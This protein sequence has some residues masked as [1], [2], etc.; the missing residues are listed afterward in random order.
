MKLQITDKMI[1][2]IEDPVQREYF[3]DIK[4]RID[5]G[6]KINPN[7]LLNGVSELMGK[8]N[9]EAMERLRDMNKTLAEMTK[10]FLKMKI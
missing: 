6:E 5:S 2:D 4:K 7:D 9:P 8:E 10:P 3:R 1:N